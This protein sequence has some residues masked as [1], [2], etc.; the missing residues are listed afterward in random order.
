MT[1]CTHVYVRDQVEPAEV[2]AYCR[3]LLG[4]TDEITTYKRVDTDGSWSMGNDLGQGLDALL[5]VDYR[6]D[7]PLRTPEQEQS[8]TKWCEEDCDGSRHEPA[9]W[10]EVAFDTAYGYRKDGEG[11]GQLHAR[12]VAKL[13]LWLDANNV[14][15]LW[16][17]E[18]TGE[19]HE[20][21][22]R[23]SDLVGGGEDA[24]A[25]F[26]DIVEPVIMGRLGK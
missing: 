21:Y 18:F 7:G 20:G 22:A 26:K 4:A 9:C 10:L 2:F 24:R 19:R 16:E 13:G 14:S 3:D 15:W 1:L 8:H 5:W 12:L 6:P 17:N 23:L 11:C 25:W